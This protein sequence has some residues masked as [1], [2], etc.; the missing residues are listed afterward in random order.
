MLARNIKGSPEIAG[1]F[2]KIIRSGKYLV[3]KSFQT[4]QD[5]EEQNLIDLASGRLSNLSVDSA[6]IAKDVSSRAHFNQGDVRVMFE[7][8]RAPCIDILAQQVQTEDETFGI[9]PWNLFSDTH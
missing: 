6:M 9:R 5:D 4:V 8:V 2:S 7:C 3:C 1:R